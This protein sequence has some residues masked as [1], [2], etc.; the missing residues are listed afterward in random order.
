MR[1]TRL[2][3]RDCFFLIAPARNY[4]NKIKIERKRQRCRSRDHFYSRR[5]VV[6]SVSF[7]F[8]VGEK[9]AITKKALKYF[10]KLSYDS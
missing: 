9:Y 7:A 8:L 1:R 10:L 3:E 6:F 2:I 5:T 4:H